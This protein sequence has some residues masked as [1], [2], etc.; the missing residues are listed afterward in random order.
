MKRTLY[1][2]VVLVL[3]TASSLS[4]SETGASAAKKD[5][6]QAAA[7]ALFTNGVILRLQLEIPRTS[8]N[9]LRNDGRIYV[10][11]RLREGGKTYSVQ[12]HIK[13]GAGS[14]R[15]VDDKPGFTV[16]LDETANDAA[17]HGLKK[18]HL[19]NSVQDDSYLSEWVCSGLFR[20]AGVPAGRTAHAFVELNGRRL[21]LYVVV[22][23]INRDF[24]AHYFK[25]T[26]GNVYGQSPNA[27]VTE[28]LGRVGG[29]DMDQHQDLRALASAAEERDVTR[30][31]ERLPQVLEVDRFL[32]FMAME[33]LLDHWDGYTFNVKNYLVH[34][35]LDTGK[36]VFIPHDMDQ[37]LRDVNRRIVPQTSAAVSAAIL[38]I[39]ETRKRY[40][41]RF[42]ELFT[43]VFVAPVITARID[44]RLAQL[45]PDLKAYDPSLAESVSDSASQLKERFR[46]RAQ[47][48]EQMFAVPDPGTLRFVNQI[49]R[50]TKWRMVNQMS[51][52]RLARVK[53][54]QGP[55]TLW[56]GATGQTSS[57]WRA[58]VRLEPGHYVFEGMARSAGVKAIRDEKGQG[59]GLRI[60][61]SQEP[62]RNGLSGDSP[63]KKLAYEFDVDSQDEEVDLVCELRA[64]QGEVWFDLE[65][66]RL[67]R[68]R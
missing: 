55:Q 9:S 64:I 32:S 41:E 5:D 58:K 18:F 48:L 17:F 37:V 46:Q 49:G 57:S 24:L 2:W 52:A 8:L 51:S 63:W 66:L 34:H 26:E 47:A 33:T 45:L 67:V 27:D 19:N 50:P 54:G 7:D 30:L 20:A 59:A 16:K 62:R 44:G 42:G 36:M 10:P 68:L 21:G 1:H 25:N 31:R 12:V 29:H 22:E 14:Y 23:N 53:D 39:P 11:A 13:G 56:I 65:S 4:L 40:V 60:S 28:S 43:N 6:R 15:P 35:D 61:G 38:R 3:L